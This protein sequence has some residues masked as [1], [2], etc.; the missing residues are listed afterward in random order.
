MND[1]LKYPQIW[2]R[3]AAIIYDSLLIVAISMA[4]GT[5]TLA[6]GQWLFNDPHTLSSGLI[7]QFGWLCVI[8]AFFCFFWLKAGQTLGMRA[9]RLKI[10]QANNTSKRLSLLKLMIRLL[11]AP[12]GLTLFFTGCFRKDKQLLHDLLSNTQIVL[13]EKLKKP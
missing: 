8:A 3:F 12:M 11:V 10:V 2:R 5:L 6:L 4:Y 9:W 13:T 7:F 1:K